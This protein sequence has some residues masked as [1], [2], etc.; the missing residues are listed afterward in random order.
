MPHNKAV[1]KYIF[2]MLYKDFK[3]TFR[4]GSAGTIDT[5]TGSYHELYNIQDIKGNLGLRKCMLS[6]Y[7]HE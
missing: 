3:T 7:S 4:T 2:R 1:Q 5:G 6:K